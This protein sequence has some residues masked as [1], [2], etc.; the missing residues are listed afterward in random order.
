[1]GLCVC[2]CACA[3]VCVHQKLCT[4]VS[5][6]LNHPPKPCSFFFSFFFRFSPWSPASGSD[7]GHSVAVVHSNMFVCVCVCVC[8][9]LLVHRRKHADH[10]R[11]SSLPTPVPMAAGSRS[12]VKSD[13]DT[14]DY[15]Q[16]MPS[17][18]SVE[19]QPPFSSS[20]PPAEQHC[21]PPPSHVARD[22]YSDS[23]TLP[24]VLAVCA[25]L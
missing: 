4:S 8:V 14:I 18:S 21:V 15:L 6:H 7:F 13:S 25:L 3:C 19:S 24:H 12:D 1:M 11:T 2:V 16:H 20:A 9:V 5:F 23:G 10:T 22:A 17:S